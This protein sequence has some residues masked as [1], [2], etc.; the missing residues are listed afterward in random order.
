MNNSLCI[1]IAQSRID[2]DVS[3]NGAQIR[4]LMREA[5]QGGARIIHFPEAAL[6]GYIKAQIKDWDQVDWAT[7]E[8]ELSS[9][10]C[11]AA[12]LGI[13]VVLGCNHRLDN[14]KR[15]HNSLYV[16]SDK[17]EIIHRYDKRYCSN[18]EVTGWYT[19]GTDPI[20]F[21]VEGFRFGCALCIEINFMEVFAQYEQVQADCILFS[22][23]SEDPIYGIQVQGYAATNNFWISVSTPAQCSQGLVSGLI[24]PRGYVIAQC[25]KNNDPQVLIETLNRNDPDLEVA[26]TKARPWRRESRRGDIYTQTIEGK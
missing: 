24:D 13:W 8:Q 23:Y 17:G 26:L 5:R 3:S 2:A 22:A 14:A 18:T 7:L 1:A 25:E 12:R 4:M 6:S 11:E 10:V 16:I 21:D 9:I 15:P 19:P 20:Y